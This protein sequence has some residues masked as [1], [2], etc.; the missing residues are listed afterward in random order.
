MKLFGRFYN[1]PRQNNEHRQ[2]N[3][4][5]Q[6]RMVNFKRFFIQRGF[7][8]VAYSQGAQRARCSV[9]EGPDISKKITFSNFL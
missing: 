8:S 9:S 6:R 3:A 4:T 1:E 7:R 5:I 2:N